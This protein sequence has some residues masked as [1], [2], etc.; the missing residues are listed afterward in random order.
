M[1]VTRFTCPI[2][3]SINWRQVVVGRPDG[4]RYKTEFA[5][6]CTCSGDVSETG[7]VHG[8]EGTGA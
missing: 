5:E 2:C 7:A 4:T 3:A 6:C 1:P 8:G